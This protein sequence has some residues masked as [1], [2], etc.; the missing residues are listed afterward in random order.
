MRRHVPGGSARY[1]DMRERDVPAGLY[2]GVRRLRSHGARLRDEPHK[3]SEQL[4]CV[5]RGLPVRD[6]LCQ[7]Y[8]LDVPRGDNAVRE[9]VREPQH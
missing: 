9:H 8:V 4:W 7:R 6:N 3:R 1:R 5:R 2:P